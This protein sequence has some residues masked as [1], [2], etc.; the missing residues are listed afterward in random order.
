MDIDSGR[1]RNQKGQDRVGQQE[2]RAKK[3]KLLEQLVELTEKEQELSA[4]TEVHPVSLCT[5]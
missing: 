1:D 3:E 4:R 2:V 5:W